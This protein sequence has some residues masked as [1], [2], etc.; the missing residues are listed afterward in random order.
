MKKY[1]VSVTIINIKAENE[2]EAREEFF[3]QIVEDKAVLGIT[4][5]EE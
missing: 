1:K 3:R 4:I 2:E 5:T